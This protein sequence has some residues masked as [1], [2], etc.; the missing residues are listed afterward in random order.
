MWSILVVALVVGLILWL[1]V[2][3]LLLG[4]G[5]ALHQAR[6][7]GWHPDRGVFTI[8]EVSIVDV[9]CSDCGEKY[10]DAL[11]ITDGTGRRCLNG[12]RDAVE[13][14]KWHRA[15]ECRGTQS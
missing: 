6:E 8:D 7:N 10:A 1:L 5:G 14:H 11:S 9:V 13:V 15:T 3:A 12:C 2:D 4:F